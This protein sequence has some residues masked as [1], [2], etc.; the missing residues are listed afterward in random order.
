V[1]AKRAQPSKSEQSHFLQSKKCI[2]VKSKSDSGQIHL[3]SCRLLF[4]GG[5]RAAPILLPPPLS[6]AGISNISNLKIKT[7]PMGFDEE[8]S[9]E[10]PERS[11]GNPQKVSNPIF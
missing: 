2:K 8:R 11:D 4:A 7:S 1:R 3:P 10:E 9:D 5:K 6:S